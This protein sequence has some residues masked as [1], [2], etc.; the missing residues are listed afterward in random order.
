MKCPQRFSRYISERDEVCQQ[1]CACLVEIGESG[2][3]GSKK[4][5]LACGLVT[6]GK[7]VNTI[8]VP[9]EERK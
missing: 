9:K 1:D 3:Y 2:N 4:S 7:P 6:K 8:E 5:V